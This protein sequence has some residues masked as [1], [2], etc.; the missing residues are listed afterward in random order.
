M[1]RSI[2]TVNLCPSKPNPTSIGQ[3]SSIWRPTTPVLY[4]DPVALIQFAT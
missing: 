3:A 4:F 2:N 1:S